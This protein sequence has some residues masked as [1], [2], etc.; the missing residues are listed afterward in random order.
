MFVE[1][2]KFAWHLTV[3]A[4]VFWGGKS[5]LL[6]AEEKAKVNADYYV[7]RLLPELIAYCKH[8]L[9]PGF[10]FQQGGAPAH[11]ARVTQDWP[12]AICPGFI[13]KN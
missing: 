3:S 12:Q 8:L 6:F 1:R 11:T 13:D 10:I 7:G 2:E 9:P 5:R 4:G